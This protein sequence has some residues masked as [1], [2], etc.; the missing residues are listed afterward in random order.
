M[1]VSGI[2]HARLRFTI[3]VISYAIALRTIENVPEIPARVLHGHCNRLA[4]SKLLN[5]LVT[6][7]LSYCR[8]D[9]YCRCER[10]NSN[11]DGSLEEALYA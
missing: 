5:N 1:V 6:I 9:K 11:N 10:R 7:I 2:R 8:G 4:T 3:K